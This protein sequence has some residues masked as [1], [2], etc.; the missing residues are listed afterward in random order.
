[1]P[2]P[3]SG[4]SRRNWAEADRAQP[5]MARKAEAAMA[6]STRMART[7]GIGGGSDTGKPVYHAVALGD[8]HGE[9]VVGWQPGG[10]ERSACGPSAKE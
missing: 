2:T 10:S 1:M 9:G 5:A 8:E 4:I 3:P 7:H 6:S